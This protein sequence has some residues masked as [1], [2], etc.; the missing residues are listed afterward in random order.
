MS[1]W[2]K[3]HRQILQ[4]KLW[5][6]LDADGKVVMIT[7]LLRAAHRPV[8]WQINEHKTVIL[9][10]GELFISV[11]PFAEEMGIKETVLRTLLKQFKKNGF[12][13]IQADRSGTKIKI[14]NWERY[15][16]AT[17]EET[18]K[19]TQATTPFNE[20]VEQVDGKKGGAEK[21]GNE[22]PF[23]THNKN[24]NNENENNKN[25]NSCLSAALDRYQALF[26]VIP[27]AKLSDF[28][29]VAVTVP[30][31]WL[32]KSLD[33]LV[34]ANKLSRKRSPLAYWL[35][36]LRNWK[37]SGDARPWQGAEPNTGSMMDFYASKGVNV[38]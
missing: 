33:E 24:N 34:T 9:G 22:T 12:I 8:S 31:D 32:T 14:T 37:A 6:L 23:A 4:S 7:L 19:Q 18:G 35:G 15:Q 26:G 2:V 16:Q 21:T 1:G 10:A 13:E 25:K 27:T 11:R 30:S 38:K 20:G 29:D 5:R 3:L 36:I 17:L 28:V